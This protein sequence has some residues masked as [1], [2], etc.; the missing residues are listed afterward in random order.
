MSQR[1][2]SSRHKRLSRRVIIRRALAWCARRRTMLLCPVKDLQGIGFGRRWL[3]WLATFWVWGRRCTGRAAGVADKTGTGRSRGERKLLLGHAQQVSEG[4]GRPTNRSKASRGCGSRLSGQAVPG[5][6]ASAGGA[7]VG[8][9]LAG[10]VALEAADD[11]GLGFTLCCA[12][13]DVGAG[14]R[15]GAHA[16][17]QDPPQGVVGL[18]VSA[19]VEPV[20]DGLARGCRDGGGGAQVRP[21]GPAMA[22]PCPMTSVRAAPSRPTTRAAMALGTIIVLTA[23]MT[24]AAPVRSGE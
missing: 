20:A 18:A 3:A 16:G 21:G 4:R 7:E 15:V 24:P 9:D 10:D 14:G 11:L 23:V 2:P 13:F 1:L 6:R 22:M 19:G 5:Y 8:V 17:E 12:A